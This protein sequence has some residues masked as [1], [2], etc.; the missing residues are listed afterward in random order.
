GD[1]LVSALLAAE[2][3]RGKGMDH[4][5]LRDEVKTLLLAGHETTALALTFAVF[6]LA[7]RPEVERRL[8]EELETVLGGR[9]PTVD[10]LDDLSYTERVATETMRLYPPVYGMLR[11]PTE[12]VDIGGYAVPE[13]TT[14]SINQWVVHRDPRWYDDPMAFR[15][16]RWTPEMREELP[17]FAYFPFSGGP[18]RCIGD[19]FAVQEA[20]LVLATLYQR[21][22]FELVSSPSLS[23]AAAITARPKEPVEA[24]VH[25]RS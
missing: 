21:Y 7:Q 2:D 20:K 13:G 1:D 15:P 12:E 25:E 23:L 24:A 6:S 9:T 14:I 8:V 18:R 17:R 19:R 4:E 10:D 22:H 16:E 5:Q 3:E 11:E